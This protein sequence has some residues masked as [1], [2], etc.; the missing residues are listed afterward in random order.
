V[1]DVFTK[2]DTS[3]PQD[4]PNDSDNPSVP[5]DNTPK[6]PEPENIDDAAENLP[7]TPNVSAENSQTQP[8]APVPPPHQR[9]IR[10]NS[11]AGLTPVDETQYGCG[12]RNRVATSRSAAN[13]AL[14]AALMLEDDGTLEPGGVEP[15]VNKEDWFCRMMEMAMGVSEDEPTLTEA[16]SGEERTKWSNAIDAEL[17][18]MEKVNAW[19]PVV[20]PPGANIIP[21]RYVFHRKRDVA[22]NVTRYKA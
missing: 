17:S 20:A 2:S 6:D 4:T 3:Q 5:V 8:N 18:Q 12:K 1:E 9:T 16:L 22:G 7:P 10:R 13:S 21:S 15:D 19:V 11:L 14:D